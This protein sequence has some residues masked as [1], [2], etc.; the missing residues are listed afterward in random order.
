[1]MNRKTLIKNFTIGFLPLLIFIIAD[2]FFGLTIGLVT[3][4]VFGMAETGFTY[5]REKRIDRFI[6]F[7]TGLIVLLG[8]ISIILHNDIFFK[9]KPGLIESILVILLGLTAFS[10]NPIL[11][12]MSGRY[13][14]G[15]E[16]SDEQMAHMRMMMRRLFV[17]FTVHTLLVFYS[18]FYLSREAWAFISGGLFYMVIGGV[19]GIEFVKARWQQHRIRKK[20]AAE[21]WFDLVQP[22]GKIIGRAPRSAVHGNPDLLHPVVHVH[23]INSNGEIFLQKRAKTKDIQPGKWDTA[24]G[25]HIHSG[26]TIE[27]A[28][29]RETEEEMGISFARFRPLF[30]YVRRNEVESELVHGF[31]LREDGPFYPNPSE[32]SG[33]RFWSL[34]EIQQ[35]LGAGVFTPNF[36]KEFPL[37][38][39]IVFND[40]T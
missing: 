11:I 33:A 39:K 28:M 25:G 37:L 8:L 27:Q 16:F 32:I 14:K 6:L 17:I 1:M 4:V 35:N 13:M 18:A 22:D 31:L 19:A 24:V 34:D 21:E 9:I 15:I 38:R 3:A 30:R 29:Q 20:F 12:R 7:D 40:K 23:I 10:G 36:E 5:Y 2:Q 26:E